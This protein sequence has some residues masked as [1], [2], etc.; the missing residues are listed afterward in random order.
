M[1]DAM[2]KIVLIEDNLDVLET[3][4]EILLLAG[5]DVSIA[6]NGIDGV[7]R[8]KAVNPDLIICDI[9]MPDLDG[10]GVLRILS[11]ASETADIP[12]IFLTAKSDRSDMRRGMNMGADDYITKPFEESE[13]LE[14][15]ETRLKKY[16]SLKK[17]FRADVAGLNEFLEAARSK[18]ELEDL[19]RDRKIKAYRKKEVIYREDDYANYLFFI[20]KGRVKC[21]KSD[22]FGKQLVNDVCGQGEFLG[23]M[24]LFEDGE[25][26]ETAVAMEATEVAV[27]PKKDFLT[28][29]QRRR[30][31]ATKFIKMLAGSVRDRENRMLQIAYT[32]VRERVADALLRLRAKE[33]SNG[34][35]PVRIVIAREDLASIV[36][37]AKE[38]L[39]RSLSD[40]KSEH[41]VDTKGQEIIILKPNALRK[42]V[43]KGS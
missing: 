31:V 42:I 10:Y 12:F 41:L 1:N 40:L 23:Y 35:E 16:D 37:T 27:I 34:K 32:P 36:G 38:S 25:Y 6:S 33:N 30:D 18:E 19:S 24:S 15:V 22:N 7:E 17:D 14:S 11:M 20:A 26:N 13:L 43:Y 8:V 4:Q 9:M 39:I 21:V 2:K 29:I 3:T 5:Y 28:L